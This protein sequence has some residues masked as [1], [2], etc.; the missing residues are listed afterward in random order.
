MRQFMDEG[1]TVWSLGR[2][3]KATGVVV[4]VFSYVDCDFVV[5][6]RKCEG[7]VLSTNCVCKDDVLDRGER[8]AENLLLGPIILGLPNAN[9]SRMT[10]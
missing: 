9:K 2:Y 7:T 6:S 3:S 10:T 5:W 8:I 4:C 1:F